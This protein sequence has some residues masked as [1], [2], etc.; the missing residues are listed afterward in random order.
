[1]S[2]K[3]LSMP[4]PLLGNIQ[5]VNHQVWILQDQTLKAVPRKNNMVPATVTLIPCNHMEALEKDKGSLIYLGLKEPELCLFCTKVNEQPTL[6]LK[7]QK[8]MDLYNQ[9]EPV[10]PFLFY[11][12]KNGSTSTF[13]SV[14]FPGWFIA[15][16]PNGGC[17]LIITQELGKFYTTD[18]GFTVLNP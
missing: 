5:D 11:H 18:F 8:I 7:E 1:M 15:S 17:P 2:S 10:K 6:Q 9:A 3:V 16:C 4:Q 14:V 13:E 12:N